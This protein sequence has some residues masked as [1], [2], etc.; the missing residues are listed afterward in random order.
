MIHT[1]IAFSIS[2][3]PVPGPGRVFRTLL[4]ILPAVLL[5][6]C[7]DTGRN[8]PSERRDSRTIPPSRA[9]SSGRAAARTGAGTR[10]PGMSESEAGN[11]APGSDLLHLGLLSGPDATGGA[12]PESAAHRTRL[13][14]RYLTARPCGRI[15]D[16]LYPAFTAG[17]SRDD[18]FLIYQD[19]AA[20]QSAAG[21]VTIL[22]SP[23]PSSATG[24]EESFRFA[25]G[26]LADLVQRAAADSQ[27]IA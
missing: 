5:A 16:M 20:W 4:T 21:F 27:S 19:R 22:D 7:E 3:R 23:R 2:W 18:Y 8:W 17:G 10:N 13:Q 14:L 6:G 1:T 15:L 11:A 24:P 25:V 12:K 9:D 26:I